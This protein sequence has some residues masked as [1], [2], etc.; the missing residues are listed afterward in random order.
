MLRDTLR[1]FRLILYPKRDGI[2]LATFIRLR[3]GEGKANMRQ[4]IVSA[5][6][7][8]LLLSAPA[9]ADP[10]RRQSDENAANPAGQG[11]IAR[12]QEL[13]KRGDSDAMLQLGLLYD[14]GKDVQQD[15]DEAVRWYRKAAAAGNAVAAFDLGVLYDAGRVGTRDAA[16]ALHWYEIAARA[17]SG[18]AAYLAGVMS[19][20]GDGTAP[21][22]AA[23]EHW[24]RQAAASGIAAARARLAVIGNMPSGQPN[25]GEKAF[26]K[27]SL[28]WRKGGLDKDNAAA[29]SALRLSA[30]QGYALAE[31]DLGYCYEH[32]VGVDQDLSL[33]FS[34]YKLAADSDGPVTLKAR[35]AAN[36]DRLGPML[37]AGDARASKT[38]NGGLSQ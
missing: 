19:E 17:G 28:L 33:A 38:A 1:W 37:G 32:G 25:A 22:R 27:A 23:A 29:L 11:R 16:E 5:L 10:T 8:L 13:A 34:W 30:T 24:Y 35:A 12:W 15:F 14:M 20:A 31:Y 18:R 9:T 2:Q 4:G 21:N 3:S 6:L 7:A 26:A 36:R